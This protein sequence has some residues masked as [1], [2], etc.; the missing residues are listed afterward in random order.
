MKLHLT[1]RLAF[2]ASILVTA[3]AC[4]SAAD[5][6]YASDD[7][8]MYGTHAVV[9]QPV[10]AEGK[11]IG[12]TLVYR[13]V[14]A[15]HAYQQGDPVVIVGNISLNRFGDSMIMGLK[16]GVKEL[17]DANAE[18]QRPNFAYLQVDGGSTATSSYKTQDGEGGF[19]LIAISLDEPARKVLFEMLELG[20]VTIGF[21]RKP[22]GVDVLVPIDLRV[23]DAEAIPP[24]TFRRKR[25]NQ[26][27]NGFSGCIGELAK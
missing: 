18:F 13:A 17:R 27:I 7:E 10:R 6:T 12:C 2:R 15:D 5:I 16:V 25:S 11:L 26:A 14:Q 4:A 3:T 1:F 9:F 24:Q 21:N 8:S 19:R 20:K 22:S 23:F